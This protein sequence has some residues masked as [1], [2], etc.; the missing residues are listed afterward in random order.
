M[1]NERQEAFNSSFIIPRSSLPSNSVHR[2]EEVFALS[3]DSHTE[4]LALFAEAVFERRD[5]LARLA[6]VCDYD[7]R[8]LA[9]HDRLIYVRDAATGLGQDLR[10]GRDDAGMVYAEDRNDKSVRAPL[11][12]RFRLARA[13][14]VATQSGL[15]CAVN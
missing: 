2:V 6:D 7:H 4:A 10:N 8:E 5:G 14:A 1:M 12:A 15:D 13:R 11:A 3:V 9:L